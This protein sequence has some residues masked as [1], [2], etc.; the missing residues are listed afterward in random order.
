MMVQLKTFALVKHNTAG[1]LQVL[2]VTKNNN[3]TATQIH[4]LAHALSKVLYKAIVPQS[5]PTRVRLV[6]RPHFPNV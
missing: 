1:P 5:S 6:I 4:R 2:F 3:L